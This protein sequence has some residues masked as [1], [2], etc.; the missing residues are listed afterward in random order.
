MNF[1]N[2]PWHVMYMNGKTTR[3]DPKIIT[4]PNI[5][6]LM[7]QIFF[8]LKSIDPNLIKIG[9]GSKSK[10]KESCKDQYVAFMHFDQH[11]NTIILSKWVSV[12]NQILELNHTENMLLIQINPR[13]LINQ[14]D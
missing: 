2:P 8:F 12:Q 7:V 13:L 9:F 5:P 10:S 6:I 11:S 3:N 14:V 1:L 4:F